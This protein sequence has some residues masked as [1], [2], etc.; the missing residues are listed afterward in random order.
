MRRD[1]L[2]HRLYRAQ[3][4]VTLS[5]VSPPKEI[6]VDGKHLFQPGHGKLSIEYVNKD[7]S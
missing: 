6:L 3:G 5:V 2:V 4:C 1:V 7:I